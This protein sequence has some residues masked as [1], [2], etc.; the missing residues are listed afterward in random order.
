M[1]WTPVD[2]LVDIHFVYWMVICRNYVSVC[3]SFNDVFHELWSVGGKAVVVVGCLP[4][5]ADRNH[6]ILQCGHLASLPRF[7]SVTCWINPSA[8]EVIA[9]LLLLLLLSFLVFCRKLTVAV[10][11]MA[12]ILPSRKASVSILV[13]GSSFSDI[14]I[15]FSEI[16]GMWRKMGHKFKT[17]SK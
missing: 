9:K 11:K 5:R 10:E 3:E 12:L 4:G 1:V 6:I 8:L 16:L 13:S 17:A 15:N 2:Q 7:F 14:F